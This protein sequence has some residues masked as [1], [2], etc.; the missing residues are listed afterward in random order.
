VAAIASAAGLALA[1]ARR[2]DS[3]RPEPV[4]LRSEGP[5]FRSLPEL[6]DASAVV[7]LA[8]V[9]SVADG[10]TFAAPGG[11]AVRSRVLRLDV[12]AVLAGPDPGPI[13]AV[14]EVAELADG[15]PVVVDGLPPAVQGDQ[16]FWFLA[17]SADPSVPYL[18]AVGPQGRY[19]RRSD[20][21]GDDRLVGAVG[22]DPL[23]R[24]LAGAGG[25]R[26]ADE[27]VA[28]ARARGR[29]VRVP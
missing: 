1:V 13:V 18:A 14:E 19:L 26:L 4:T 21:R 3:E 23:V 17:A 16:G 10:R 12:G 9:S 28:V 27:V 22:P 24:A 8:R 5:V 11:G 7:V 2:P 6:V 25:R 29:P 20:E 15:T